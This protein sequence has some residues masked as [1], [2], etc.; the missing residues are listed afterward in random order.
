MDF[1]LFQLIGTNFNLFKI[2]FNILRSIRE[3]KIIFS[4]MIFIHLKHF[5]EKQKIFLEPFVKYFL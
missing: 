2:D 1:A 3:I 5:F 4:Y